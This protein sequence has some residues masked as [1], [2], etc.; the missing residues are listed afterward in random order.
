MATEEEKRRQAEKAWCKINHRN[1]DLAIT[2]LRSHDDFDGERIADI[3]ES[4][5]RDPAAQ[6]KE[7]QKRR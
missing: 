2:G 4:V 7:P 5:K 1:L 3:L 6:I